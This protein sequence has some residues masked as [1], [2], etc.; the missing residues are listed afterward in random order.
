MVSYK[1]APPGAE[2]LS[3]SGTKLRDLLKQGEL[4]L[5]EITRPEVAKILIEAAHKKQASV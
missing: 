1:S 3:I 4:P 2:A 5:P